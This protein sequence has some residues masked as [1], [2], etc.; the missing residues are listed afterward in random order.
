MTAMLDATLARWEESKVAEGR[1]RGLAEGVERGRAEG[2]KRGRAEGVERGLA[3]GGAWPKV[4]RRGVSLCF[5]DWRPCGSGPTWPGRCRRCWRTSPTSHAW[6]RLASGCSSATRARHCWGGFRRAEAGRATG[7]LAEPRR[8]D[9]NGAG[10][11]GSRHSLGCRGAHCGFGSRAAA[12]EGGPSARVATG[13]RFVAV[14][15]GRAGFALDTTAASNYGGRA[16]GGRVTSMLDT[17]AVA[18]PAGG[19]SAAPVPC[20]VGTILG[21]PPPPPPPPLRPEIGRSSFVNN[22]STNTML[23]PNLPF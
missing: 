2:V 23:I 1:R 15:A 8:W 22:V 11:T 5:A 17:A 16:S 10:G 18:M 14:P 6:T 19:Q 9:A 12:F 21:P 20:L 4:W 13:L 7:C 3:E